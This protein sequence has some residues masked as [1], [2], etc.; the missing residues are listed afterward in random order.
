M[1]ASLIA[2]PTPPRRTTTFSGWRIVAFAAIGLGMSGP[3]QTV[4]ISVFIDPMMAA[5]ELT[6]SEVSTA[7]LVGT[8]IGSFALPRLGRVIDDRGARLAMALVGGLFGV[9]LA[10]MAGVVG[11]ITLGIGFTGIRMLGQ[12]ALTLVST[13][14]VAPWFD[15]RRGFAMG[16][17]TAV[18]SALLSL[19]PLLSNRIIGEFGW[20]WAWV[21]MAFIVWVVILPIA[22]RGMIDR[23]S[24]VGQRPDGDA[25]LGVEA[26]QA[27][28]EAVFWG[29]FTRS[30]AMRAPMFWA[31]VG[32]VAAT[33]MIG[34]GLAF[35]QI[36]LLGE[37][38]LTAAQAAANFIPQTVA[39]LT[40]TLAVG[41]LVDR[42]AAKWVLA[43]SMGLLAGAM[44]AVPF[45][46]PGLAAIGYGMAVGAA[47]SAARA[48]EAAS[49][50]KLFGLRH[51]GSIRGVVSAVGAASTAFG[52][53]A[54]SIGRDLTGSYVQVLLWLLLIP[55]AV[56][57]VG[58]VAKVPT[59]P[60]QPPVPPPA[61][62]P[63]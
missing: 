20:R 24:D 22:L 28:D 57:L 9:M 31:V 48:L 12:G 8:L 61:Q 60:A 55:I 51:V 5:L 29:S 2:G 62:P 44:L 4:G 45:V 10:G 21:A 18:G 3:G 53:L 27:A 14:A 63:E 39:A 6:R 16:V 46:T 26:Q 47:G 54:L 37:Q 38:G 32:A 36:D 49:F 33:G 13:T 17:T 40:T 43:G 11:L 58:L 19:I 41:S 23:P 42:I 7:Y 34:T 25:P 30:E 52:P 1:F 59:R 50:P 35:H 15:R 56:T